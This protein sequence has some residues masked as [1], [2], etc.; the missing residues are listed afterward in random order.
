MRKSKNILQYENETFVD[1][2]RNQKIYKSNAMAR[3]ARYDLSLEEQRFV[4]YAVSKIKKSDTPSQFYDIDIN[5]FQHVC[6]TNNRDSY[7]Y[8]KN[9]V[10]KLADRSW[11]LQMP[12]KE[13]LIRWFSDV[14]V[15][16]NSSLVRVRFHDRMFPYAFQLAEQMRSTGEL[17]TSYMYRYVLPMR[18][19]YSIRLYELMKSYKPNDD[20][21]AF[22]LDSLRHIMNC[23]HYSRYPDFRV[24]VLELATNEINKFTDINVTYET[25]CKGR[26]VIAIKFFIEEKD[27]RGLLESHK[28]ELTE[29]DGNVHWWDVKAVHDE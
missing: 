17:Y 15:T 29:L 2:D 6:G 20:G 8:I 16:R 14:E 21:W 9:W 10:K 25:I 11:W 1:K 23:D 4:L 19:T 28:A 24:N 12:D 26:K 7:S 18:S 22:E 27:L 5:D 13:V 3:N